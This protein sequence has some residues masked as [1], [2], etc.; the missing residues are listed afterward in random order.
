MYIFKNGYF[1]QSRINQNFILKITVDISGFFV[2]E[3]TIFE[4]QSLI[5]QKETSKVVFVAFEISG[6]KT[7]DEITFPHI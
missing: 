2:L 6:S 1:I 4:G 3:F 7:V 5:P